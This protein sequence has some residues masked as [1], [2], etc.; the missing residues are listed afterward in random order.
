MVEMSGLWSGRRRVFSLFR[1]PPFV[2]RMVRLGRN[3]AVDAEQ[4]FSLHHW[5]RLRRE[6]VK[7]ERPSVV[8]E[9]N[10]PAEP[11]FHQGRDPGYS[12]LFEQSIWIRLK[13]LLHQA[14]GLR[15]A[16]RDQFTSSSPNVRPN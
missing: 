7:V 10:C 14:L 12:Q 6:C 15:R 8:R 5:H 9:P 2:P 11:L 3:R 1:P 13:K 4:R 16:G